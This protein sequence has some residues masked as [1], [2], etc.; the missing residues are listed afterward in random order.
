M[1]TN[2]KGTLDVPSPSS[3]L[4]DVGI[5]EVANVQRSQSI[6]FGCSDDDAGS[7]VHVELLHA[8]LATMPGHPSTS[9]VK[10]IISNSV[11]STPI[12]SPT[13]LDSQFL[14]FKESL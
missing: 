6:A 5:L 13:K 12:T 8:F 3:F 7:Y 1:Y 11:C 14:M 10:D 9:V 4:V 2:G